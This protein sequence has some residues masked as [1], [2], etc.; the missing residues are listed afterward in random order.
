MDFPVNGLSKYNMLK[1]GW[2]QFQKPREKYFKESFKVVFPRTS[3]S[4]GA[5]FKIRIKM[6]ARTVIKND[7]MET[8]LYGEL[9]ELKPETAQE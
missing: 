2:V 8:I 1:A 6:S 7:M 3:R 4:Q 5:T 9:P